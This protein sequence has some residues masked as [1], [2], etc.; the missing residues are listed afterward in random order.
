[1]KNLLAVLLIVF[2][3]YFCSYGN[4]GGTKSLPNYIAGRAKLLTSFSDLDAIIEAAGDRKLALLGEASHGTHEYYAWRDSISRRLITEKGFSFIAVEGDWASLYELNRYVKNMP[5]AA[6]SAKD[7]LLGLD[8]WPLWMWGNHEVV[9]LA[10]WLREHN[11]GLPFEEKVGFY[12]MDVYDEWRSKSALL[13]MLEELNP[14]LHKQ[15]HA[16]YACFRPFG[17]DSW[18]YARSVQRGMQSCESEFSQ[19]VQLIQETYPDNETI[20]DYEKFYLLQNALVVKHAEKFYRKAV[21]S[22]DASSWNSRVNYMNLT[23]NRLLELYGPDSKGIVWAHN[24]HVGDA[25]FTE[26]RQFGQVNIGQLAREQHGPENVFIV[27]FS[28][29]RGNVLAGSGW[30]S[31][32][33]NMR[34]PRARSNSIEYKFNKSGLEQFVLVFTDEDRRNEAF[35][36]PFG[37]RAIGVVY[38]PALDHQQNYVLS[39]VPLRYDAMI[40][41][42]ETRALSPLRR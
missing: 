3:F 25:R 23:V 15:V 19:A 6:A 8:R 35:V 39:I 24:T 26:M 18:A 28:T 2:T 5:G 10:E 4:Q 12:G 1:M 11:E 36:E 20:N 32:M 33:Q 37:N 41:F 29:Y 16:L 42:R 17:G 34:V 9:E 7:V 27:G 38:N 14:A 22:Q 21:A 13:N 30:A 31:E 40:F